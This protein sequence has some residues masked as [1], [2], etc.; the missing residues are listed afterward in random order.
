MSALLLISAAACSVEKAKSTDSAVAVGDPA[1]PVPAAAAPEASPPASAAG[2]VDPNSASAT[3]I[4]AIPGLTSDL[5][6]AVVAGRPYSNMVAV[7]KL[8]SRTLNE[9]QRDSVYARL[10]MPIELNSATGDEILVIPGVGAR[11]RH[12]FEEYRPY[13][14]IEQFR[15]EIGKYVDDAELARL[16]QYVK[17]AK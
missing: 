15:R 9:K 16:E 7:D 14:S 8:L 10:F 12:E 17:I 5:A 4:A 1:M 13:K 2:M 6:S 3:D 11:M